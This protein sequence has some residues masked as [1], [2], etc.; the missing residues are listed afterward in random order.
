[1][2]DKMILKRNIFFIF[3]LQIISIYSFAFKGF[4]YEKNSERKKVLYTIEREEKK[5]DSKEVL[6]IKHLTPEGVLAVEE[7]ATFEK[8]QLQKYELTYP[9]S[10]ESGIVSVNEGKTHFSYTKNGKTKEDSEKWSDN[11]IVGLSL[12]NFIQSHWEDLIN[13]KTLK[14]RFGVPDRLESVGFSLFRVKENEKDSQSI[15]VKMKPTS[16]IIS[17]LVD[18]IFFNFEVKTKELNYFIG[19][20][21]P[22]QLVNGKWKD[23]DAETVYY[24][25]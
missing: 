13:G 1:M 24:W 10:Q 16:F 20:A 2:G 6:T 9:L 11:F 4:V 22:K 25:E 18:P 5:V 12:K 15:V 8:N 3:L 17:A 19:R 23:L 7:I 21:K 14:V